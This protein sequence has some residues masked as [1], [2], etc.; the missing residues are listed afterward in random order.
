M[1][2]TIKFIDNLSLRVQMVGVGLAG[3][4]VHYTFIVGS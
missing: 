1:R 3:V 4:A 2:K